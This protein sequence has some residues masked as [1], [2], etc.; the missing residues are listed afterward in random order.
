[1]VFIL[2]LL[3]AI[4]FV[5]LFEKPLKRN[6]IP[7]YVVSALISVAIIILQLQNVS[8]GGYVG[9]YLYPMLSNAGLGA[10][11]FVLVMYAA[12][13][14]NGSYP[15]K[16]LIPIRGQ[17]SII[18]SIL[19]LAHVFSFSTLLSPKLSLV[20]IL[21]AVMV[22]IMIPLFITSFIK[23]RRR[24][25]PKTWK[26]LQRFAYAFYLLIYLHILFLYIRRAMHGDSRSAQNIAVY[27]VVFLWYFICRPIKAYSTKHKDFNLNRFRY[28]SLVPIA[29][30]SFGIYGY[31]QNTAAAPEQIAETENTSTEASSTITDGIYS[32]TCFGYA[33]DITV[34]IKVENEEVVDITLPDYGDEPDYKHFSEDVVK[35]LKQDPLADVDAVSEATFS[36]KA[37]IEAYNDALKQAGIIK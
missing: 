31:M 2:S 37:V 22:I 20:Y 1:M 4:L 33:G 9:K 18:A 11:F 28:I 10:A 32:A 8:F 15:A 34:E 5:L 21:S 3:T 35:Q 17:L 23:I 19:T 14:E 7:F 26:S 30:L 29:L 36:T 16:L 12:T 25:H 27:S 24:M 6:P 13:F